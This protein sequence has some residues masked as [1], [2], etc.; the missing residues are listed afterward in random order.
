MG[1]R[2]EKATPRKSTRGHSNAVTI[3]DVAAHVGVTAMTVSRVLNGTGRISDGTKTTVRRAIQELG[4]EPNLNAQRLAGARDDKT[5]ALLLPR[6]YFDVT[7]RKMV[8]LQKLLSQSGYKVPLHASG[9][10]TVTDED[11]LRAIANELRRQ[12]PRAIVCRFGAL[13]AGA[14]DE[15]R[16]YQQEGGLVISFNDPADLECDEVL[17]DREHNSYESTRYL[18]ELGHRD[19]GLWMTNS[20]HPLISERSQGFRRALREFGV[21]ER[22]ELELHS[23]DFSCNEVSGADLA[24]RMLE[25]KEKERPTA[26]CIV[27]DAAA[28]AFVSEVQ[29]GGLRVPHDMSVISH[30]DL[31]TARYGGMPLT[32]MSHPIEETAQAIYDLLCRRIEQQDQ[33]PPICITLRGELRVR[34]ST[35]PP[36]TNG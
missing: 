8:I 20:T 10:L 34:Q 26:L 27:N 16:R 5:V 19:I 21:P 25:M 13:S 2:T 15:V 11:E 23:G 31:P 29:Q 3:R 7:L 28:Q 35:A 17:F 6:L 4:Y 12:K 14:Q 30:D 33:A 36:K 24:V 32:A 18:L 22:P 1:Q 9:A